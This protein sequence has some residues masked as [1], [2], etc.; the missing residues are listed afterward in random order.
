MKTMSE[1]IKD[2]GF[3]PSPAMLQAAGI[4]FKAMAWVDVIKP[5]VEGYQKEILS[6]HQWHIAKE[7]SEKRGSPDRIILEPTNSYLLEDEDFQ[8]YLQEC[9]VARAKAGLKVDNDDFCPLLVAEN[10]L[11]KAKNVLIDVMSTTTGIEHDDLFHHGL[12]DYNKYIDLT[13][14]LLAP[15][16]RTK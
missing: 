4:V 13:L 11:N 9:H 12:E 1:D 7:W 10:L 16:L 15:F 5:V 8:T 6:R 3:K 2:K 14:R